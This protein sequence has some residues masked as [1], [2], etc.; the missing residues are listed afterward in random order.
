[1]RKILEKRER[2]SGGDLIAMMLKMANL[3]VFS[4]LFSWPRSVDCT[5]VSSRDTGF[6]R[7]YLNHQKEINLR[8]LQ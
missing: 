1:M 2:T 6:W 8:H 3:K 7:S 5:G 4:D